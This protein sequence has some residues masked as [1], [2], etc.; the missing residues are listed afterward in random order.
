MAGPRSGKGL[1]PVDV[2]AETLVQ[3]NGSGGLCHCGSEVDHPA[4][5][6]VTGRDDL[7]S[8][9]QCA[10]EGQQLVLCALDTVQP[11]LE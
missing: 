6:G 2:E 10:N 9:A 1:P 5:E 4:Q 3:G 11:L 8:K 7:G